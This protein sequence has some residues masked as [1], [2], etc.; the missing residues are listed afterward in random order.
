VSTAYR[1]GLDR[2]SPGGAFYAESGSDRIGIG[3]NVILNDDYPVLFQGWESSTMRLRSAGWELRT[4]FDQERGIHRLAIH[5]GAIG[6][7]AF[8]DSVLLRQMIQRGRPP[9]I[10]RQMAPRVEVVTQQDPMDYSSRWTEPGDP[11][12]TS[13]HSY[14]IFGEGLFT[15]AEKEIYVPESASGL[16]DQLLDMQA[17][18]K[19]ERAVQAVR[20]GAKVE[21]KGKILLFG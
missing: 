10:V 8:S 13:V 7:T 9:F 20:D 3:D 17:P 5:N 12:I 1:G 16:L 6:L 19:R 11:H 14:N 2:P 4:S 18:A 21:E 15:P